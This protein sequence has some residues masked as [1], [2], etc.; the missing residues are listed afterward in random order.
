MNVW[1]KKYLSGQYNQSRKPSK[2]LVDFLSYSQKGKAIDIACGEGRNAIFLAKNGYEVDAVDG[3]SVAIERA[4]KIALE[5][6][7]NINFIHADLE[8]Y[9][10]SINKYDL[11]INFNYLQRSLI[12][13]IKMGLKK[14]GIL[15]FETFTIE[16]KN[17]DPQ[18]N[19]EFLLEYN[20]L[21]KL[22][23]DL[24]I[25]FYRED[26]LFDEERKKAIASIACKKK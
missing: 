24:Y 4:R 21:I 14:N 18:K 5:E 8:K 7:V 1:D 23:C 22:F 6:K 12:P 17:I 2:F 26:I 20:E 3:S 25:F 11:I 13:D 9:K 10:I 15:L 19:P 16:Q